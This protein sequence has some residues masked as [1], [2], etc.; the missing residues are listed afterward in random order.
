MI[1]DTSHVNDYE[2]EQLL[3]TVKSTAAGCDGLPAWLFKN[4]SVELSSIVAHILNL[5]FSEGKLPRQWLCAV[6][7]PVPKISK[8]VQ[9]SDFRPISVTPILSRIAERIISK[10]WIQPAIASRLQDQYAFKPTGSTTA[11]LVHFMHRASEMLT[12]N[13]YVRWL[14]VD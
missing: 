12:N 10:S 11:A 13:H 5:S 7:T 4:C 3:R 14:L 8:P 1:L 2:V 9:L 6:V